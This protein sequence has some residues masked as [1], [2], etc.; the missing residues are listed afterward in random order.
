MNLFRHSRLFG[1]CLPSS[2]KC[3]SCASLS[4]HQS[5]HGGTQAHQI[6]STSGG[7]WWDH[8]HGIQWHRLHPALE[9]LANIWFLLGNLN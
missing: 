4:G 6:L 1:C 9:A 3:D 5:H 2:S 7:T 8:V